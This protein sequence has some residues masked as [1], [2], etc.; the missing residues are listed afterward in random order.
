MSMGAA[1]PRQHA[2]FASADSRGWRTL[3]DLAMAVVI[4]LVSRAAGFTLNR[5]SSQPPPVVYQTPEQGFD[6]ERATLVSAA[7][8]AI[9]LAATVLQSNSQTT[10]AVNSTSS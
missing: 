8:L 9:A 2:A 4:A 5:F 7:P 3:S 6:K 10:S 1:I